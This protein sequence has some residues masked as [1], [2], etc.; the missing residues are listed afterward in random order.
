MTGMTRS[1]KRSFSALLGE[2]VSWQAAANLPR[3][4]RGT[5]LVVEEPAKLVCYRVSRAGPIYKAEGPRD[6]LTWLSNVVGTQPVELRLGAD[7]PVVRSLKLPAASKHHVDAIIRHQLEQLLPWPADKMTFDYE[8]ENSEPS[9]TPD[10]LCVRV[11]AVSLAAMRAAID[12]LDAAGVKA[13]VVGLAADPFAKLSTINLLPGAKA[14]LAGRRSRLALSSLCVLASIGVAILAAGGWQLHQA[15]QEKK[16]IEASLTNLRGTIDKARQKA[17]Q[18][19]SSSA[20]LARKWDAASMVVLMDE[21]SKII[22]ETTYLT[23]LDVSDRNVRIAGF[24]ANAGRLI[25]IIEGSEMLEAANFSAP[26]VRD[27]D[28]GKERF[29]I[30]AHLAGAKTQ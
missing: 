1:I 5:F 2:M 28:N 6:N 14:A 20:K 16:R 8:L 19:E 9:D 23:T 24:S 3:R 11:V 22:P 13:V 29:E 4:N 21:L 30:L 17:E 7:R 25:G 15:I 12:P 27:G 10:Q 26:V 18:A